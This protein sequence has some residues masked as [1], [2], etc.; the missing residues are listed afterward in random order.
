M[1]G[2][3]KLK[4]NEPAPARELYTSPL[5]NKRRA[6]AEASGTSWLILSAKHGVLD[7]DELVAPYDLALAE[8]GPA[9]RRIWGQRAVEELERRLDGLADMILEVHAGALYRRAIEPGIVTAGGRLETPLQGLSQGKQLAWYGQHG[10]S[11]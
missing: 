2:C 9:A 10:L 5:W 1:L 3:V 8:L 4:C 7:P 11:T 6:Y